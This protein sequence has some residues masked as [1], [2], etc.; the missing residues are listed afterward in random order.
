MALVARIFKEDNMEF[1]EVITKRESVRK[2]DG[3]KPSK[4]QLNKILEAGRLAPTA[5]NKQ[6]QRVFVLDSDEALKKMDKVTSFRY[7]AKQALLICVDTEVEV[8]LQGESHP[9]IDGAIVATHM[10]L[11]AFNVG[12]DTVWLG[13]FNGKD[14]KKEFN[15]SDNLLPICFI[16]LGF[17][18]SDYLG[19]P[20]HNKR[21]PIEDMVKT[22]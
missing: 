11:E 21:N 2:F 19:N 22:I 6:P 18:A 16:D 8:T 17:R 4:E 9:E 7:G 15:L 14:V 3:K 1:E 13:I 5:M 12:V 20:M 10:L